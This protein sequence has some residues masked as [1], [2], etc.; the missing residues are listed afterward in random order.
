MV[1]EGR[2]A[3]DSN[4]R[5]IRDGQIQV[6]SKVDALKR[7]KDDASDVRSGYECGIRLADYDDYREGDVIECFEIENVRRTL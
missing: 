3:R 5:L 6:E 7:F 4:A 2:I 1:V